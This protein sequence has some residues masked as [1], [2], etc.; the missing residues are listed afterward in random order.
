[1]LR[2]DLF[3]IVENLSVKLID[4]LR[5]QKLTANFCVKYLL[6][7]DN[8]FYCIGESDKDICNG[9]V[10]YYQKHLTQKDLLTKI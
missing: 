4:I 6:S 3:F 7:D 2:S 9:D 1:M 10:L 8:D 5:T